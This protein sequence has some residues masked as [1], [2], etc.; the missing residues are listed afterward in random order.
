MFRFLHAKNLQG[1]PKRLMVK[2]FKRQLLLYNILGK[3]IHRRC[4]YVE[5]LVELKTPVGPNVTVGS[6]TGGTEVVSPV[7]TVL[8]ETGKPEGDRTRRGQE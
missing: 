7:E 8:V 5:D 6:T 3:G 1:D 4:P 2:A